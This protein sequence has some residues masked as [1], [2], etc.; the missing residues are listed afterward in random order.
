MIKVVHK[1]EDK[2]AGMALCGGFVVSVSR[3]RDWIGLDWMG[4]DGIRRTGRN[5]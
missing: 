2:L 3:V 1:I 5:D 4:S